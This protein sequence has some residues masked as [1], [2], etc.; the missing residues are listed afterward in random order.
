[1]LFRSYPLQSKEIQ[2]KYKN[3]C[4]EI[5]GYKNPSQSNEIKEKKKATCI[6]NYGV[7]YSMQSKEIQEK[8]KTTCLERYGYEN[9]SQSNEIKEKKKATCMKNYGVKYSLQ[10]PEIRNKIKNNSHSKIADDM[11]YNLDTLYGTLDTNDTKYFTKNGEYYLK[12]EDNHDFYYDFT[13]IIEKWIV[14]F[15]GTYIHGLIEGQEYVY[16]TPVEEIHKKD[17]EKKLLAEKNGYKVF[18]VYEDE[19]RNNKSKCLE[20][21]LKEIK[22]YVQSRKTMI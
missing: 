10:I 17:E 19:Y 15:Q 18:Y 4:L 11:C 16:S 14:E 8:Y 6:K 9:P 2:E 5:Y 13:N 21:L 1:M 22:N 12:N 20:N 7:E 3:T